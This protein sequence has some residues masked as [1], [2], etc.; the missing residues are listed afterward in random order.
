[1][2][3]QHKPG[4]PTTTPAH[5]TVPGPYQQEHI[6]LV[7]SIRGGTPLNES[8]RIAEST[9]TAIMGRMSTYSGKLVTWEQAMASQQNLMPAELK[10]GEIAV[11]PVA[12]PGKDVLI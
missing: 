1:M 10:M 8:K 11:P 3:W 6:D 2:T 4:A 5:P 12:V 7:N 9:M